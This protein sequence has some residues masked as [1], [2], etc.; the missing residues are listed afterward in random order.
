MIQER[1]V[2]FC[3]CER[4]GRDFVPL[5]CPECKNTTWNNAEVKRGRPKRVKEQ[6]P[7]DP[8]PVESARRC[9]PFTLKRLDEEKRVAIPKP[10]SSVKKPRK[11]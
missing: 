6:L 8:L 9:L 3:T 2:S 10:T 5:R 7:A 4:C 1:M 11:K